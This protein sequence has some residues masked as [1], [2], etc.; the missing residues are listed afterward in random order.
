MASAANVPNPNPNPNPTLTRGTL[1]LTLT[2]TPTLTRVEYGADEPIVRSAREELEGPAGEDA[3]P[4]ADRGRDSRA[5]GATRDPF[6]D[7]SPPPLRPG[8]HEEL[9]T[10][11]V[12]TGRVGARVRL[13]EGR[14]PSSCQFRRHHHQAPLPCRLLRAGE[15]PQI[16][17]E[18][19]VRDRRAQSAATGVSQYPV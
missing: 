2:L 13:G 12:C 11:R 9:A 3:R 15:N 17:P 5:R 10:V 6:P 16:L 18:C 7:T 1:T 8:G 4:R 19:E 14:S